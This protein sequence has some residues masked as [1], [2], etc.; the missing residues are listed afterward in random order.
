MEE[1]RFSGRAAFLGGQQSDFSGGHLVLY[2]YRLGGDSGAI[3]PAR[4][5][6][7]GA[8]MPARRNSPRAPPEPSP[9]A[10]RRSSGQTG[11]ERLSGGGERLRS[12]ATA[13]GTSSAE[14]CFGL[15]RRADLVL[16]ESG[17]QEEESGKLLGSC[18][19]EES[20]RRESGCAGPPP[21]G[22]VLPSPRSVST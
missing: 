9:D 19:E 10:T 12:S 16:E 3:M 6:S 11:G 2:I 5:N 13:A 20:G 7:P 14:E 15:M 22:L 8:T 17:R 4:R 1:G 21:A 18:G